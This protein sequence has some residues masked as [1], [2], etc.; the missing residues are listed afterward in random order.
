MGF[1]YL[2]SIF[3]LFFPISLFLFP[4]IFYNLIYST[5]RLL[6]GMCPATLW[7]RAPAILSDFCGS[8]SSLTRKEYREIGCEIFL[9]NPYW[10]TNNHPVTCYRCKILIVDIALWICFRVKSIWGFRASV[11]D[12]SAAQETLCFLGASRFHWRFNF[13]ENLLFNSHLLTVICHTF[14]FFLP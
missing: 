12:Y 6:F 8:V 4:S 9:T 3:W 10:V 5:E 7:D 2:S 11:A 13:F 1:F 14:L